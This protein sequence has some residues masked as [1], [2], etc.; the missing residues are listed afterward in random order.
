MF[1]F[2]GGSDNYLT[3]SGSSHPFLS[4]SET[5]HTPSLGDE[6]FEIPPISL[7]PDSALTV[8]DVVSHFGELSDTGPSDTRCRTTTWTTSGGSV[9]KRVEVN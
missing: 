4:S 2:P 7:D 9:S 3:I 1:Q 5:F 8:S 6:E